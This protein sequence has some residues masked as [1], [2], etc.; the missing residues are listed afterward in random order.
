MSV[1]TGGTSRGM[2]TDSWMDEQARVLDCDVE[3]ADNQTLQLD[4]DNDA[5]FERA[6]AMMSLL[7]SVAKDHNVASILTNGYTVRESRGGNRHIIVGLTCPL[8]VEQRILLQAVFGSD[9]SRE[10]LSWLGHVAG[11]QRPIA[12]FV[13]RKT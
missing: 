13:P 10:L 4:I 7:R 9:P 3:V 11:R 12:L 8:T 2:L 5:A 1:V 6:I